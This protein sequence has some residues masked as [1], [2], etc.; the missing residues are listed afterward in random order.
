MA[1]KRAK[2][3][4]CPNCGHSLLAADNYCP[5]C[6]QE[7]HTHK[8]PVRHFVVELLSGLFNFDTK[9]LRT[10]R[11]LFWPPGL[12]VR[13]FNANKRVRYVPPLRLYLFAS[14]LFFIFLGWT[15]HQSPEK[16]AM[17]VIDA[18]DSTNSDGLTLH[19]QN[20]TISDSTITAL[21]THRNLTNELLDGALITAGEEPGILTRGILRMAVGMSGNS[22]RTEDFLQGMIASFSKLLFLLVPFFALLVKLLYWRSKKFYSEHLVFALYFHTVLFI[23]LGVAILIGQFVELSLIW[24]ILA[25]LPLAY[26]FL[27]LRTVHA[28]L[29]WKALLKTVLLVLGYG[30]VLLLSFATAAV[31]GALTI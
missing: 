2:R 17:V 19:L 20:G 14:V 11:D 13:E 25:L 26:L 23:I 3:T 12:V 18:T 10:L 4:E 30:V 9:L 6:G 5:R 24:V 28:E 21:S 31:I 8:L 22:F 27:A 1:R 15:T 16:E 7:N 29:V